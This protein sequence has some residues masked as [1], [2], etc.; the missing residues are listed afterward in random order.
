MRL[1]YYILI[2]FPILLFCRCS[3]T[4]HLNENEYLLYKQKVTIEKEDIKGEKT[5]SREAVT[6]LYQQEENRKI[7]GFL[8]RKKKLA[9]FI[10][11]LS[12]SPSISIYNFGNKFYDS[13]KVSK[14]LEEVKSRYDTL[15]QY[16]NDS[17]KVARLIR[18][19]EK[20]VKKLNVKLSEGN[21]VMRGPGEKPTIYD[22]TKIR[23]TADQMQYFLY[24]NG[25][26]QGKVT[27]DVYISKRKK[28][29]INYYLTQGRPYKLKD[30]QYDITDP[31]I[32]EIVD[33]SINQSSLRTDENYKKENIEAERER[34]YKLMKNNGY[35]DFTR[36]FIIFQV[37]TT[38]QKEKVDIYTIIK[39]P[40]D[41][42]FHE[43]YR[44]STIY[45]NTDVAN[46]PNL[47]RDTAER[48]GNYFI[49]YKNN[50]SK[51][52][53]D[54]RIKFNP[55]ELYSQEKVQETQIQLATLD[56][57]KFININPQKNKSDTTSNTLTMI[58]NS[59]PFK[60]YQ[61]S[62]EWGLNVGQG[63]IPGPYASLTF[64]DRNVFGGFEIFEASL[65]YSLEAVLAQ[66][67]AAG[68]ENKPIIMKEYGGTVSLTF[69]QIFFPEF[70]RKAKNF[71]PKTRI[72]VGYNFIDRPEYIRANL[73]TA[74]NYSWQRTLYKNYN[75]ALVDINIVN[76]PFIERGFQERLDLLSSLGN[77]LSLS[78]SN[79]IVTSF[80]ASY[81]LNNN[82][83]GVV[84]RSKYFK[85]YFEF[86]GLAVNAL[87][88]FVTKEPLNEFLGLQY[89]EFFKVST[90]LRYYFPITKETTFAM[91][92]NVG[93]ARPYGSSARDSIFV[94]PYEK[95][96]FIG[97][98]SSIRA[99]KP[100]R[101]GPGAYKDTANNYLY[102]QPGHI[103]L[104]TSY[105]YRANLVSFVDWAFFIDAGNVWTIKNEPTRPGSQFKLNS[106]VSQIAVGAGLGLR[107]DFT[108]L[109]LRFDVGT[110]IWDPAEKGSD[111]LVAKYLIKKPPFGRS[112]QTVFNIGIGYPF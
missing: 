101:L 87:S 85:P 66:K 20:K 98:S 47:T 97:G 18:K 81:T 75:I 25:Y 34:L 63:F 58:I 59:S 108:F 13:I 1:R 110:K 88:R 71:S 89:F 92:F 8:F 14:K 102:E 86:G 32:K 23:E 111:R 41:G 79:S 49:Y 5:L 31:K 90:D 103:I 26:F 54:H 17:S 11:D 57:Y 60:K 56:M 40:N 65:R 53:L 2:V 6:A 105:E 38:A 30:I 94:L 24:A 77:K 109:I 64:K 46:I 96:F 36:Q 83:F 12:F 104:E 52:L 37:D 82:E 93:Y 19:K 91:R 84:K 99:W 50:F 44:I 27:S 21:W 95:Y 42:G 51:K 29:L 70:G 15:I 35:Y 22:T 62:D 4:K 68:Q 74:L 10:P 100:R 7:F 33:A 76:T 69:P 55:Y 78:F 16:Q 28:V 107:F 48:G 61:I 106:F 72:S 3:T 73:R 67:A 112:E 43:Q 80:N 45:F 9:G 39:N